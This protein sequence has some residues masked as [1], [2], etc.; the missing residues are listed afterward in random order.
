[1]SDSTHSVSDGVDRQDQQ[2]KPRLALY[3]YAG[4]PFCSRVCRAIES[5]GIDVELRDTMTDPQSGRELIEAMG[6]A[7]VPVLRIE[8]PDGSVRWLP[9]SVEIV[10][11]LRER[12]G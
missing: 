7:T 10:L 5:L 11:Y 2:P 9:E 8:E 3:Q 4:C 1:M 6:R 12:F